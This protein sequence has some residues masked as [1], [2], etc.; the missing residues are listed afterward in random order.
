MP[1]FNSTRIDPSIVNYSRRLAR[2]TES[3]IR[4]N[5][6]IN[7]ADEARYDRMLYGIQKR[8][9]SIHRAGMPYGR[10]INN[11]IVGTTG[12]STIVGP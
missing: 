11:Y 9:A 12:R 3:S 5:T 6:M 2:S 10:S 7:G 1:E 8:D 4:Y